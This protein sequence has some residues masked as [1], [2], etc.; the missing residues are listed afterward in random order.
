[1]KE[2]FDYTQ[3]FIQVPRVFTKEVV[4]AFDIEIREQIT[5]NIHWQI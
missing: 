2:P 5:M 3:A 4:S 1:M